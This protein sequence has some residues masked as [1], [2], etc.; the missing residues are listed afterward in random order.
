MARHPWCHHTA[1]G[2][3]KKERKK[4][5]KKEK[6]KEKKRKRGSNNNNIDPRPEL[7]LLS[8]NSL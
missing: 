7:L 1:L 6:K 8:V 3:L 2:D 4:E 5:R